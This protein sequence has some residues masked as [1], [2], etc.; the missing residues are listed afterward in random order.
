MP[1]TVALNHGSRSASAADSR[2]SG[3]QVRRPF[4]TS[5]PSRDRRSSGN[6]SRSRFQSQLRQIGT[7]PKSG[8][9]G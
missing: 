1:S 9:D 5:N 3:L 7:A 8:S 2:A 6:R 4:K